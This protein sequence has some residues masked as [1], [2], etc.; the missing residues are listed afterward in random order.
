MENELP[1]VVANA[2]EKIAIA[3]QMIDEAVESLT[4]DEAEKVV[5]DSILDRVEEKTEKIKKPKFAAK[6]LELAT[7]RFRARYHIP[8]YN[9]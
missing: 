9:T 6:F 4:D 5:W 3:F 8:E 7:K 2:K 1:E